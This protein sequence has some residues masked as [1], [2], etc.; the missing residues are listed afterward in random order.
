M[1]SM[2]KVAHIHLSTW[3]VKR[4]DNMFELDPSKLP[5]RPAVR[6]RNVELLGGALAGGGIGALIQALRKY[7]QP[8]DT[9]EK[10]KPSI[11]T[12]LGAGALAGGALSAIS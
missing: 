10:E 12:G 1:Q 5:G 2:N 3:L 4:A 7:S 8:A 6:M 11:L 9:P